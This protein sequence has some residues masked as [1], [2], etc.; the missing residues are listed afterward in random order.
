MLTITVLLQPKERNQDEAT[1]EMPA[2]KSVRGPNTTPPGVPSRG[3]VSSSEN[4]WHRALPAREAYRALRCLQSIRTQ[5]HSHGR[6][7]DQLSP[8]S[9]DSHANSFSPRFLQKLT[10][11]MA[12]PKRTSHV[13][14]ILSWDQSL[15]RS[16]H[17]AAGG[18]FRPW[19]PPPSSTGQTPLWE[20]LFFCF[21]AQTQLGVNSSLI[22]SGLVD[23]FVALFV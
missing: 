23:V 8:A 15:Q 9:P 20:K 14:V 4:Q 21:T 6:M 17:L 13:A 22:T 3:G 16:E 12:H 1:R 5:S 7:A 10:A 19:R 11:N 2:V 18:T